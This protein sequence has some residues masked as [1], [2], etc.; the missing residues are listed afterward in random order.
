MALPVFHPSTDSTDVQSV[1]YVRQ[2]AWKKTEKFLE[3]IEHTKV[4]HAPHG[5]QREDMTRF[6]ADG[7]I[8][9]KYARA[10][11]E[12][13]TGAVVLIPNGD[14]GLLVRLE[15]PTAAGSAPGWI[16]A[17]DSATDSTKERFEREQILAIFGNSNTTAIRDHLRSDHTLIPMFGLYRQVSIV[18]RA[19]YNGTDGRALAG[20]DSVGP[21]KQYWKRV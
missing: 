20:M 13:E 14:H 21:R 4:V 12:F 6:R 5:H 3:I 8:T 7:S 2:N 19:D 1:G 15:T 9:D 11:H 10:F 17:I 16:V 18:G